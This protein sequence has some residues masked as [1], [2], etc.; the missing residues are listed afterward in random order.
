[1][2]DFIVRQSDAITTISERL[3][4]IDD[5]GKIK[6]LPWEYTGKKAPAKLFYTI[7]NGQVPLLNLELRYK[8]SK[9]AEPQFQATAT[10]IFKNLMGGKK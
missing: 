8:G 5:K 7:Y 9:T 4:T 1:M 10:P 2:E 6:P 3:K